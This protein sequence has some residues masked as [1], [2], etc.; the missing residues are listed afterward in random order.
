MWD[1]GQEEQVPNWGRKNN[2]CS[3]LKGFAPNFFHKTFMNSSII[4]KFFFPFCGYFLIRGG[5]VPLNLAQ[6]M[7]KGA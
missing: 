5:E 7:C 2:I 3:I 4:K 1:S 6:G